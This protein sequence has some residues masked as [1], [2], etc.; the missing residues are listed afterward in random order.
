M[1]TV[2]AVSAVGWVVSPIIRRM[3]SLVQSYMSSQYNWKSGIL[4]DLKN[5]EATLMDILLVVGAAERQHVVDRNQ[6]LLLQQ[7]K[8]AVSDAEDVLDE[9][10]HMLLK[11]KVEQKG[12]LRRIGSSSLS[13][14]KRLVNI[15]NFR[16]NLR[17]V[18]KS[19]ERVRASAEMFV[20]VMALQGFNPIQSLQ[21][22]PART[23]GSL[24]H[25]DAIF[26]REKEIDELMGQLLYKSD[27]CFSNV[28]QSVRTEV[29]TIV[30]VGGIGKTTLAQLIYNDERILDS[31]D[32]R[33]WV[34]VSNNFDKIRITKEIIS[35]PTDSENA[36]LTNFNF[37]KLQ[38]E[39]RWR[40]RS[41]RFLLVL[42]DVWYNEKYGEHINKQMWMEIIAPI[43]ESFTM[44]GS[45]IL[46]TTRTELVSKMLD[47]RSLFIL[48]GLGRD[49]SWSLFRQCAFGSTKPEGYPELKQLGYQIVQ[50]LKGSPLALKVVGGHL[51]GKFSDAE[52]EDV[53][54]RDVLNPNDILTI[55]HLSYE[56]LP[57]HLQQCFAYCSL[58]PKG[59]RI[60]SK[61]LIWMWIAQG[62]VHLEGNNS[63]NLE[64]V[65]RG[66]FNDLLARSFFQVL[67]CGDQTY[68]VMHDS[69]ND[70]ALHVSNG[71]CFRVDHGSVGEFPHYI[72]HLSVSAERL[73]DLVNYDGLRRLRTFMILN[74][75][76]FCSK[77]CLSHDILNK[78]KSVRVLDVSGCCFG[79]FPE[80]VNDLMHLRYLAIRRTY[81]PLPTTISRLNHLQ[82]LFVLYHSCYS[83]RISCSNKWKQLKYLRREVNTT[84]GH[85]SLPESIHGLINLVHVDV[86]KAYTLMLSGVHQLPCVEGSGEFLVDKKE[87]SLV[88]LKDLNKIRGELSVRFLENVKNREEAVK[89]RL[90]LKEHISKLELEWGSCDGAHDMDKGFEVLDVLK[91][92]RNLDDLTISG[93]PGVKSPS[94][95]ESDWLRRL[96]LICLR[97]CNRWEVLPPLGDLPFLRTL[98][99]RRM[100]EIKA[101]GQEFFGHAGFPSLQ[102]LLLERLPKLEW[103]LVDDDKVLQNLRH[104]SVAGCPRLRAYPTHPRTL[105][106]IAVLDKE[107]INIKLQMDSF[108]LSRSFC[109][110]VSSSFHVLRSHHLVSIEH[111]EIYVT[112]LVQMPTTV[113][114]NMKS[115]KK[116]KIFGIDKQNAFLVIT[117]LLGENGCPVLPLSLKDLVLMDCYLQPSSFS[118][119]L[120]NLSSLE[121][122]SLFNCG[123]LEITC[124]PVSLHHWRMLKQLNISKCDWISSIEG[125][126]ALLSLEVMTIF[127][128]Y[129]LKSVPYLDDMPCLQK[130]ELLGCPQV[131]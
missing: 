115:L 40:L 54:Q 109:R 12:L 126:E 34:S 94:W 62:L 105:R 7:M 95:L 48:E 96:K 1:A 124:L 17:K 38:E 16:S 100:E 75:S 98:E 89:S 27:K 129:E 10:D 113:F 92:H 11:E 128:C 63:R 67:R 47:S 14:G 4:S 39:L 77:V 59:Y 81:Y 71:E 111:M 51:N 65:G 6:I 104:L 123:S 86:E 83:A 46:V 70:L 13:V 43:K 31:F 80:A 25:E 68:Y 50:K 76:W 24:L 87:Q 103:C 69:L 53:L 26:G 78:L 58:F 29:H 114:H 93:Y 82:S 73:G 117:T 130:L 90:D 99:V 66:Y 74:D 112:S 125:S 8:D 3:A 79:R 56:S 33:M 30:G 85:F 120:N 15:D 35:Y 108:E 22:V 121:R 131:M 52:W 106:H 119:F 20:R 64:D 37:S 57:E 61:R 5:L 42:D 60:D 41:K 32:V 72:R 107:V 2:P 28:Y 9:F 118:K 49:D 45:K 55:L 88:R 84:G 101:L 23:T 97:D 91:P 19:L 102:T 36:E 122:I 44:S 127:Y 18:L 21:C 116:L 110:V